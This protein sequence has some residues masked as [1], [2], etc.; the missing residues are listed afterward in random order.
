MQS[1]ATIPTVSVGMPVFN[2]E[3]YLESA[4]ESILRQD[5]T[6]FELVISDN[7]STDATERICR[8]YADQDPRIRYYR[9]EKNIGASAN[10]NRVFE[11]A[12]GSFFKWASHDDLIMPSFLTRCLGVFANSS[13]DVVLAYT[14]AEIIDEAGQPIC[15]SCDTVDPSCTRPHERLASLLFHRLYAHPLWGLVRPEALRKTRM[16][17]TFEADHILLA[18]LALVGKFVE[19]PEVLFQERWHA[20]SAAVFHR[21]PRRL[22]TWYDPSKAKKKIILPNWVRRNLA[23]FQ[24]VR[25]AHLRFFESLCCYIVVLAVPVG[26]YLLFRTGPLRRRLGIRRRKNNLWQIDAK[27]S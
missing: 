3:R 2:G 15:I 20:G 11:L 7:A 25:H 4:L 23:Y 12:R 6:D 14:R 1:S 26:R 17:G 13:E 8:K 24:S 10:Y 21:D 18:E 16:T 19:I 27:K 22:L 5:Y 9:N